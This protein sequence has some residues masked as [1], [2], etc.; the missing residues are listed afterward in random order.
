MKVAVYSFHNF[1]KDYLI[2]ANNNKHELIFISES[3]TLKNVVLAKGADA[4]CAFVSDDLGQ[5]V[6]DALSSAGIKFIALR[7]AGFN[8]LNVSAA[9][10]LG[11][12]A[13]RVPAYS[14][15]SV[16]EHA[17]A[18]MMAL[19]RKIVK[20]NTATHHLNFS[21]DGMVGFD[22]KGKTVGIIGTGK[23]GSVAACIL[24]GFGC[25]L[26]AYDKIEDPELKRLYSV[27][28]V[29]LAELCR[30]SDIVTLHVPLN[31]ETEGMI[32]KKRIALMKRGVMLINTSRGKLVN[33]ADVIATLKTGQIG[34]F[35]MDVYSDESLFFKDHSGEILK[36]DLLARLMTFEN[37]II[38][39]HQAFLT[40]EALT[41]I[42]I[43]T[44]YNLDCFDA[45]ASC[46]NLIE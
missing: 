16:A 44:I 23:I 42:A 34:S 7:S 6:L 19:N 36:D 33:S 14:P 41:N 28:Y 32:N 40:K 46:S 35:G 43:T 45:N 17:I 22:M 38:T 13:A 39:G 37:V 12:V 25:T 29:S 11:I 4:V 20:A 24:N 1:E 10:K 8:H 5:E 26:L 2:S 30:A 31:A 21:L 9:R 15:Y 3:L 27:N 18:L